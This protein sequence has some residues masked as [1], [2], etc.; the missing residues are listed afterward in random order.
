MIAYKGGFLA[1]AGET[2]SDAD[3]PVGVDVVRI[4]GDVNRKNED[5]HI[6]ISNPAT[7]AVK[8]FP[9]PFEKGRE[10]SIVATYTYFFQED[11]LVSYGTVVVV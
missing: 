1:E 7:S 10:I 8:S 9:I 4:E 6:T 2:Y 3:V 11:C 5:T